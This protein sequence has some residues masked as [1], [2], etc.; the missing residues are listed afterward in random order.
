MILPVWLLVRMATLAIE[1]RQKSRLRDILNEVAD[2]VSDA[3]LFV[4]ALYDK[5][6]ALCYGSYSE[7]IHG[8]NE[9]VSLAFL[10][11][12]T[13]TMVLFIVDWCGPEAIEQ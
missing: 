9:R 2:V 11:R 3:A 1:S 10:K 4:Y 5:I 12:I 6:P 13:T 7:N 8:F